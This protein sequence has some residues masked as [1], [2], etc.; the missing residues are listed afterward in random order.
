MNDVYSLL[1][2]SARAVWVNT[3]FLDPGI[4]S[5]EKRRSASRSLCVDDGRIEGKNVAM[6]TVDGRDEWP[7][8][9]CR[10]DQALVLDHHP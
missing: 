3:Y 1:I 9:K 6:L 8:S 4:I 7:E 10:R 5:R 2:I